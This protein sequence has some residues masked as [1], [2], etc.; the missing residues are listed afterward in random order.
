[1]QSDSD[2]SDA[3]DEHEQ[4]EEE[5][6]ESSEQVKC[7]FTGESFPNAH[8]YFSSLQRNHGFDIWQIVLSDLSLDFFKFVKLINFLRKHY[9]NKTPPTSDEL[10]NCA[11][12]WDSDEY[13]QPVVADDPLLQF[14]IRDSD[15]E[16]EDWQIHD[17]SENASVHDTTDLSI[18]KKQL[19]DSERK[20]ATLTQ[21]LTDALDQIS[22]MKS[23]MQGIILTGNVDMYR[24]VSACRQNMEVYNEEEYEDSVYFGTY[25]HYDIHAEMLQDKVRTVSYKEA[26]MNNRCQFEGKVVLDVGC[27]TGILSMFAAKAGA[28]HVYG[29]DMSDI[30]YQAMDIVR[31]NNLQDKVTILKGRIEEVVLPVS[32]VDI[33]ISEW[34]GYFLLYESM[35]DSVLFARDKWLRVGGAMY[36]SH[37][38]VSLLAAHDQK[39]EA[40]YVSFWEDV[41]GFN[42][43]SLKKEVLSEGLMQV[44]NPDSVMSEPCRVYGIDVNTVQS[45]NL[46]YQTDFSLR[47]TKPGICSAIVGYFDIGFEGENASMF[48]TSPLSPQTHWKQ[49]VFFLNEKIVVESGTIL[50]G[51][52]DCHKSAKD[53]RSLV[54]RLT[55]NEK[56]QTFKIE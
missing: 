35:L 11:T 15:S 47:I 27:G 46:D 39:L 51:K 20:N 3:L 34:M 43:P 42:M 8:A 52:I 6:C 25:S 21:K 38:T 19:K 7:I 49:T 9:F 41:Y 1:M 26:I 5:A 31:E 14:M 36:P 45:K 24:P 23:F 56:T 4:G 50:K 10:R 54:V 2:N 29:I 37:C 32:K 48:T 13:L 44:V 12:E 33:I 53:P 28:A 40:S 55:I 16:D 18:L 30:A 22:K 17:G